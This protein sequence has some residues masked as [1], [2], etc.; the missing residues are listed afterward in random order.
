[1]GPPWANW[2]THT[3][4]HVCVTH[5]SKNKLLHTYM[6]NTYSPS[7]RKLFCV[8]A[9]LPPKHTC[10]CAHST[11]T[12]TVNVSLYI[13]VHIALK[14]KLSQLKKKNC[15]NHYVY[16]FYQNKNFIKTKIV[17]GI[18]WTVS[19]IIEHLL[20]YWLRSVWPWMTVKV[21]IRNTWCIGSCRAKFDDDD[22]NS[23]RGIACKEHTQTH[24]IHG[25]IFASSILN[26]F[27]IVR[28]SE[29]K[30]KTNLQ[31]GHSGK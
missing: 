5:P 4:L 22:L 7:N 21:N 16:K 18:A 28:D 20:L 13:C 27:K 3:L 15:F 12:Q 2:Q 6:C 14:H 9:Q 1:M 31:V 26:F 8:R 29:N 24:T 19:E 10:M 30:Q 23:F 25:Q 17:T 11:K